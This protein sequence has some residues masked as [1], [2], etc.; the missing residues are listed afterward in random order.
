MSVLYNRLS[1]EL[2]ALAAKATSEHF[3]IR[4]L[5]VA[6]QWRSATEDRPVCVGRYGTSPQRSMREAS[7]RYRVPVD[8][9]RIK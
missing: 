3:R 4:L 9:T 5:T 8:G 2:R 6:E 7:V 1:S